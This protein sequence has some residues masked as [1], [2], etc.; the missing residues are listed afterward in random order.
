MELKSLLEDLIKSEEVKMKKYVLFMLLKFSHC[1]KNVESDA[2]DFLPLLL[3]KSDRI[4]LVYHDE[5][6]NREYIFRDYEEILIVLQKLFNDDKT[7]YFH[8]ERTK[9]HL[10]FETIMEKIDEAILTD[11]KEAFYHYSSI[12]TNRGE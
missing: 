5:N 9:P 2:V 7:I 6:D 12:L 8:Y 11:N 3:I 4:T 10:S 1:V